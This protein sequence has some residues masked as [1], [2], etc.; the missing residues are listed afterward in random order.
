M[1]NFYLTRHLAITAGGLVT[2]NGLPHERN[3]FPPLQ[4]FSQYKQRGTK[5]GT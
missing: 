2:R 5:G 4:G 3:L 1:F